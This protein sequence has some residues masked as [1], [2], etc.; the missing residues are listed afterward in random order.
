MPRFHGRQ[1]EKSKLPVKQGRPNGMAAGKTVPGP[2]HEGPFKKGAL[3]MNQNLNQLVEEHPAR[4]SYNQRHQRGPAT[5]QKK[6]QHQEKEGATDP[7]RRAEFGHFLEDGDKRI[8]QMGMKPSD[9]L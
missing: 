7:L 2:V 9:D 4:H 5:L 6:E 3:P 1:D 8:R